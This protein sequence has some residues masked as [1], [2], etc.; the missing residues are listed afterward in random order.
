MNAWCAQRSTAQW[1]AAS[2]SAAHTRTH[3]AHQRTH[4][5]AT[6]TRSTLWLSFV[7]PMCCPVRLHSVSHSLRPV[8]VRKLPLWATTRQSDSRTRTTLRVY[9]PRPLHEDFLEH[10]PEQLVTAHAF[11]VDDEGLGGCFLVRSASHGVC[12]LRP[13]TRLSPCDVILRTDRNTSS[14][15]CYQ[16]LCRTLLGFLLLAGGVHAA[17]RRLCLTKHVPRDCC[18]LDEGQHD[19]GCKSHNFQRLW[20]MTHAFSFVDQF[21][22]F[23]EEDPV[24]HL[25]GF[26]HLPRG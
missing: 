5:T 9:S 25:V 13:P 15:E 20:R 12:G 17:C 10:A 23:P 16:K 3:A 24:A 8:L 4:S 21:A 7:L 6:S 11:V 19:L 1:S 26:S 14:L 2:R 18:H 22:H